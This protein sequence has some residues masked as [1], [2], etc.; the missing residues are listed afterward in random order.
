MT[1]LMDSFPFCQVFLH[2]MIITELKL[3]DFYMHME[4]VSSFKA[5]G[6]QRKGGSL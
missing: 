4:I 6:K 5:I 2:F 3:S 1:I